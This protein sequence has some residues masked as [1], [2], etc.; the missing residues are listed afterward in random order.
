MKGMVA[1]AHN[2][3]LQYTGMSSDM[4]FRIDI[5]GGHIDIKSFYRFRKCLIAPGPN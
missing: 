2:V 1:T 5:G 3:G 4:K